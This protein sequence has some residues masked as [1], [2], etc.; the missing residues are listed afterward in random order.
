MAEGKKK[1]LVYADWLKKFEV[2]QDDEAGRLAK[3]FFRYIND[4]S[5]VAP[6]RITEIAFIDIENTLKR[7]LVKW[8]ESIDT[9]SLNGRI[10][11]LKR[12]SP[13]LHAQ[14]VKKELTIDE[15]ERIAQE[16]NLS[17]SDNLDRTAIKNIANIAVS[18]SDSVSVSDTVI[19][20][21]EV[22]A[23]APTSQS[24]DERKEK[25]R[26]DLL[27]HLEKYGKEMIRKFFDYWTEKNKS[28]KKMK[29]E[30]QTTFE[31]HLRLANWNSREK[32]F[33]KTESATNA[34]SPLKL[35]I[36]NGE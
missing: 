21:R 10:G 7:D 14:V 16:R 13:D 19:K 11:N 1:V 9:K 27:P 26:N 12:W 23:K 24:V 30:M 29:F 6:D 33:K 18:V 5:P 34:G 17:H 36:Y 28:G 32:D 2:L 15:A 35:N 22:V 4:L 31:L 3:H 25:F 8:E 20:K